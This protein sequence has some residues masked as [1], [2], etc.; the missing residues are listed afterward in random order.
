MENILSVTEKSLLML[1]RFY[2]IIG[3]NAKS[4]SFGPGTSKIWNSRSNYLLPVNANKAYKRA[5]DIST[6]FRLER[7]TS[8]SGQYSHE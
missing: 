1:S 6:C 8:Q 3:S 2:K 7:R 5:N 4:P